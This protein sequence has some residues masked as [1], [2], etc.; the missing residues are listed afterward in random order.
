MAKNCLNKLTSSIAVGCTVIPAGV[1]AIYLMHAEDVTFTY[2]SAGIIQAAAFADGAKAYKVEGYR[3]NIQVTASLKTTD[4][5]A[6]VDQSVT[7]KVQYATNY[8]TLA[9]LNSVASGKF[10]VFVVYNDGD[11]T[12]LGNRAALECSSVD[13]DSNAN[14]RMVTVTLASPEGS[15]GNQA[16]PVSPAAR[17]LIISKSV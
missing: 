13:F 9:F 10:Y 4:A 3:Q 6:R 2:S 1:R 15:A 7:F 17:D 11:Y 16:V 8:A 12:M 5:S 14:A